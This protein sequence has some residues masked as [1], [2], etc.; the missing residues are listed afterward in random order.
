MT[1]R[2]HLFA[3]N[4]PE[5]FGK[6][7]LHFLDWGNTA[8]A[9]TV[10]CVHGLT[11]NARDFDF[12]AQALAARGKRVL[13]IDMPGRGESPW[14]SEPEHYGY[15]LY[16]AACIAVMDNFHLRNVDWLGTSMGG[17]IGMSIAAMQPKRIRKLVLNDIGAHLS[18]EGLR[19]IIAYVR[20]IPRYFADRAEAEAYLRQNFASFGIT[21]EKVWQHFIDHSLHEE[22]GQWRLKTDPAIIT[23]MKRDTQDFTEIHAVDLSGMWQKVNCPTLIL[24]GET[25]DL[26][27]RETVSAMLSSNIHARAETIADCGHAPSLSNAHQIAILERFLG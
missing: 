18:A 11:R 26:L 13:A 12:A 17:I 5:P 7:E 2:S 1:P 3:L 15:P 23:P 9:D 6:T 21:E 24:R 8:A 20:S 19:R 25:S 27:T 14:L 22:N 16:I 10:V 4:L